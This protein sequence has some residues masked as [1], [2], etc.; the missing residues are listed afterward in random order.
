MTTDVWLDVF[1]EREALM[2]LL[3]ELTPE[4]WDARSLC[5]EWRVRDVVGHM[6]SETQMTVGRLAVG[7]I[8]SGFRLNRWIG[9]DARRRG[10]APVPEILGDYRAILSS[11][12]HLASLSSMSMLEDIV[13]HQLDIRR[14]LDRGRCVSEQRMI[15]VASDLHANRFF[16]G[17]KLFQDLRITASDAAWSA[18]DGPEVTGPIEALVLS[19]S[20]RFVALNELNGEGVPTMRHRAAVLR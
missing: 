16:P 19:L 2:E 18:G 5:T 3:D 8:A 6:V 14:P 11:R 1:E 12:R 9:K 17:S 15:V 4:Q 10:A 13:V 7:M 20:G